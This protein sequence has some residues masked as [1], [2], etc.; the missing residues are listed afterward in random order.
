[1]K[2][3]LF[4]ILT[5]ALFACKKDSEPLISGDWDV[6]FITTETSGTNTHTGVMSLV[7]NGEQ[8]TGTINWDGTEN[9]LLSTSN[10]NDIVTIYCEN[11]LFAG[12][13][14]SAND[15]M[16]GDLYSYDYFDGLYSKYGTWQASKK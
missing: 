15:Q 12:T 6:T 10:V 3:V 11:L 16:S 7:Q 5:M 13:I 14:N 4:F 8:L 9:L 2:K 1:V